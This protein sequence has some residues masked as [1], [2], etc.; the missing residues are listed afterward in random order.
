[1]RVGLGAVA[2]VTGPAVAS[3][4][5]D[6]FP[7][8]DRGRMYGLIIGGELAGTGLGFVVSGDISSV[9]S[10]RSAFWWL[11]LPSL[12]LAWV[13]WRLA[14]PARGGQSRLAVGAREIPGEGEAAAGGSAA[15]GAHKA[16]SGTGE[17]G[18]QDLAATVARDA[19]VTPDPDL[20]LHSDPTD[21]SLWWAARYVLRIR[22]NVIII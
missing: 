10:W 11:V 12:A 13:V 14:E 9:L 7:A 6:F 5:G 2:A 17:N 4:V 22:T 1:A 16:G 8:G 18:G 3:L 21:R 19:G 15:N 20:V